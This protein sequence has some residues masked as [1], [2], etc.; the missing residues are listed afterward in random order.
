MEKY[1]V[2]MRHGIKEVFTSTILVGNNTKNVK[3][4]YLDLHPKYREQLKHKSYSL[5]FKKIK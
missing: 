4:H 2:T 3:K 1:K 5:H